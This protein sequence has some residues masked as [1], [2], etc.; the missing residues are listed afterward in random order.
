MQYSVADGECVMQWGGEVHGLC[1]LGAKEGGEGAH[2]GRGGGL[3]GSVVVS[4]VVGMR[5]WSKCRREKFEEKGT[6]CEWDK[7]RSFV[8]GL[9]Q[10]SVSRCWRW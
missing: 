4:W 7:S 6:N 2:V 5:M 3:C 9:G 8:L 10:V 1:G